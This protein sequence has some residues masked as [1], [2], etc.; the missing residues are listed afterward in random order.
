MVVIKVLFEEAKVPVALTG[1]AV[2]LVSLIG[3]TP[4]IFVNYVAGILIDGSPS[5]IGYQHFFWF[6]S[7]FAFAGVIASLILM[8]ML[9]PR[10]KTQPTSTWKNTS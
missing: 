7:G 3:Y 2:G 5:L 4:D 8:R 10:N 1:T 6:L 9:H